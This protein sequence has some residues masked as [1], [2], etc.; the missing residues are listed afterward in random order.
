MVLATGAAAP[1]L[2]CGFNPERRP[3][4]AQDSCIPFRGSI[5]QPSDVDQRGNQTAVDKWL[6][7][8]WWP[9]TVP[10]ATLL[11]PII[12]RRVKAG[13]VGMIISPS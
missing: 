12:L 4:D 9:C 1:G 11:P 5:T 7:N 10:A 6:A 13:P 2:R 8:K 3:Q